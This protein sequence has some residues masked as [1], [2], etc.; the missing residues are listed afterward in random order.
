M[1]HI[2]T[3]YLANE[4]KVV[5]VDSKVKELEAESSKLRKELI[6]TMDA[7]NKAKEQVKALTE[8]LRAKK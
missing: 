2:T 5:M 3:E 4:E 6:S 7:G 8:E 1:I